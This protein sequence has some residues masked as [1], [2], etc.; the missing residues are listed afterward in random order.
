MDIPAQVIETLLVWIDKNLDKPLRI[1][2]VSRHAGYSRWHLQRMFLKYTGQNLARY[3]RERKLTLAARDLRDTN[4]PVFEICIRYGFDSQ[5]T[6]TRLFSKTF[7]QPPGMY[8]K[9]CA[10]VI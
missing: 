7:L 5:Q 3:I 10:A 2:D 4:E 1:E 6:F 8:R 9:S